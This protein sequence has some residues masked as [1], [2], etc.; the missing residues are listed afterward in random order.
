MKEIAD[1]NIFCYICSLSVTEL[2]IKPLRSKDSAR[3]RLFE[4]FLVSMPSSKIQPVD[5][6]IAKLGAA[7][8][9]DFKLRTP[10]AILTAT[11]SYVNAD[12]FITNDISLKK[13]NTGGLKILIMD[14]YL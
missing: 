4:D 10:D 13:V 12:Y 7:I 9:A 6:D 11:A 1:G 5:Y 2:L 14:D 3:C 8:R